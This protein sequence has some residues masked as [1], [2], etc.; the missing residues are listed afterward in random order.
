LV[1]LYYEQESDF[2]LSRQ[3]HP[4]L[5]SLNGPLYNRWFYADIIH[6]DFEQMYCDGGAFT[7]VMANG[8]VDISY[9][10]RVCMN[11]GYP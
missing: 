1:V 5:G 2:F 4:L 10:A 7:V 6:L 9:I 8:F 3:R 11:F